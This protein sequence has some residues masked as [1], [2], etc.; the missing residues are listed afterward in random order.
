MVT[1]GDVPL[2]DAETLAG[3]VDAHAAQS[4]AATLLTTTLPD[5]TGYG[6]IM[7]TQDGEVTSIVEQ[8][9]ASPSQLAIHEVNAAV[10]AFDAA[11]L[12]SALT[13]L[14]ADNAQG[15]LYLTDAIEIFRRDGL[16]VLGRHVDD[17]ALVAGVND[18]VQLADLHRE[19]NRRLVARLQRSG[20]SIVDP[21]TT[22]I[23]VDV[24]VGR[25]TVVAPAPS[26]WA[27]RASARAV[28]S[29]P[30]RR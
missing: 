19:L 30:T 17:S 24:T 5:P 2:L 14:S 28:R 9:D 29:A 20:V 13:K 15:E 25:D 12:R 11:A 6:R 16:R 4:A 3:L 23:D 21:A 26:C 10:Y 18:R 8:A 7:R 1:A 22:W 27:R